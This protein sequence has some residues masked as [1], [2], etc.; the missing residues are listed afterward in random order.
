MEQKPATDREARQADKG[1]S[2]QNMQPPSRRPARVCPS[3]T[4]IA[5][6][7][8]MRTAYAPASATRSALDTAPSAAV[9]RS[10]LAAAS[11]TFL[12]GACRQ[13]AVGATSLPAG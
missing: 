6:P 9:P 12:G 10:L 13:R 4:C 1:V 5:G 3:R 7:P 11:I 8:V 2:K